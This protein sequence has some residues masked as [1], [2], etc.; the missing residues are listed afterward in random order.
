MKKKKKFFDLPGSAGP[1]KYDPPSRRV[2]CLSLVPVVQFGRVRT[3][4]GSTLSQ[5]SKSEVRAPEFTRQCALRHILRHFFLSLVSVIQFG[6]VRTFFGSTLSQESKSEVRAP[7][8]TRHCALRNILRH[9]FLSL[10][11]VVQ[12][13]NVNTFS[14][15][16]LS[17]ES[18][19]EVRLINY[20]HL[21]M[22]ES[23]NVNKY[24]I[25]K[26]KSIR[27]NTSH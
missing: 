22:G 15:S 27:Y 23:S 16:A 20:L 11:P 7:E 3:F 21:D 24:N 2:Y 14:G 10:V 9:F 13:G 17:Q 19:S 8:F 18:K 12:F 26:Y 25:T 1:P 5:E 6:C 4:F